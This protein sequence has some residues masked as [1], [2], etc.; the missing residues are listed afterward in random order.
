MR[1]P[2]VYRT[3][4]MLSRFETKLLAA[5]LVECGVK[6]EISMPVLRNVSLI[7]LPNVSS[8]SGRNSGR[9]GREIVKNSAISSH[10]F[11]MQVTRKTFLSFS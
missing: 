4:L 3:V 7:H 10:C 9:K 2:P 8:N 1:Q 5:A 6:I 11:L